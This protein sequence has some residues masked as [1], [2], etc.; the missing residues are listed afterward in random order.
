MATRADRRRA[1]L[2]SAS[3]N[4]SRVQVSST[5]RNASGRIIKRRTTLSRKEIRLLKE[6]RQRQEDERQAAMT[7]TQR[8]AYD[9]MGDLPD[10][11]VE[12]CD[13]NY[14][15]DVLR[16]N[17]TAEISHAGEG[18]TEEEMREDGQTLLEQ[19]RAHQKYVLATLF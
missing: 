4:S 8:R 9:A 13:D 6:E 10:P 19:L 15:D 18:P 1:G 7:E 16:G 2:N 3:A 5:E 17:V 12:P 14:E 11:Y